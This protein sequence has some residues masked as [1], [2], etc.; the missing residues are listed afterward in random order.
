MNWIVD[1]FASAQFEYVFIKKV[2]EVLKQCKSGFLAKIHEALL[3]KKHQPSLNN[4]LYAHGS[5][6]LLNVYKWK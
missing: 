2:T 3:T 4:H 1:Q 5:F 6:F